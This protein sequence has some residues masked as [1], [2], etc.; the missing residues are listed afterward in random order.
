MRYQLSF[1]RIP[2]TASTV[3]ANDGR[4]RLAVLADLSQ[5]AGR[6]EVRVGDAMA[7]SPGR[8][9]DVDNFEECLEQADLT[10]RLDVGVDGSLVEIPI[11]SLDDFHPDELYDNVDFFSELSGLRRRLAN[12][13]TFEKAAQ[14]VRGWSS[15]G[16][17]AAPSKRSSTGTNIPRGK[18]SD[19][20]AL[21]ERDAAAVPEAVASAEQL[22]QSVVAPY[23]VPAAD[24]RQE[25][26]VAAVDVA[27]SDAMRGIL[28]HPDFQS[29]ESTWRSI[30]LLTR[31]LETG[32]TLEIVLFDISAAEF[33]ADLSATN[34]LTSTGLYQLLVAQ[35]QQD[36]AAGPFSAIVG[37]YLFEHTPPHADLLARM[38]QIAAAG[39]SPFL[40]GVSVASLER[41][42]ADQ[43]P[44]CDSAWQGL[45]EMP[46]AAYLGLISPRFLLRWPYGKKTEPIDPF[47]FEEFTP[48]T[49]LRGMLWG[50]A[51]MLGGLLL[52][53][54]FQQG[55]SIS[56]MSV[57]DVLSVDDLPYYCYADQHGDVTAL[58]CG[59]RLVTE[60]EAMKISALGC[61]PL[62]SLKNM[63]EV[64]LGGFR[65]VL[66]DDLAGPWNP[67][68]I[69]TPTELART[70]VTSAVPDSHETGET[71]ETEGDAPDATLSDSPPPIE[72]APS[73]A[74]V[75][76]PVDVESSGGGSDVDDELDA[77]LASLDAEDAPSD[78][79]DMDPELAKLLEGL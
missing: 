6:G 23:V 75:D 41:Q 53:Q 42:L 10:L 46:E 73:V 13:S 4:F 79:D 64:R 77:L 63:P 55:E 31:R 35:P 59:E 2:K 51:A 66:G 3:Q 14:E 58:P 12:S 57:G 30:D 48:Q 33:A 39:G 22:I 68:E 20:A 52:G 28:H 7:A 72:E 19:F 71:S 9:V 15:T 34:E 60:P 65:S 38:A 16:A 1:G 69:T 78:D 18:L 76:A 49:G 67:V 70:T 43:N 62:V 32:A 29:V 40:T 37:N 45:R 27:L 21:L 56:R 74:D 26:L 61:I 44:L 50:N 25:E 47:D 24:P 54:T 17:S 36:A 5:R 8:R 11:R